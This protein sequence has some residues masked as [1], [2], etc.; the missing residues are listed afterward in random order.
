MRRAGTLVLIA[1]SLGLV[2][3]LVPTS[4]ASAASRTI[5]I[6]DPNGFNVSED[7]RDALRGRDVI[8]APGD[9]VIFKNCTTFNHR[10]VIDGAGAAAQTVAPG[11][12]VTFSFPSQGTFT[13]SCAFHS[14]DGGGQILVTPGGGATTTTAAPTTIGAVT[15]I[16]TGTT[17]QVVRTTTTRVPRTTTTRPPRTTTTRRT[18]STIRT[19]SS[20]VRTTTTRRAPTTTRQPPSTIE[21]PAPVTSEPEEALPTT[22]TGNDGG[23]KAARAIAVAAIAATFL[24]LVVILSLARRRQPVADM[25][26]PPPDDQGSA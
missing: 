21:L 8:I 23:D 16:P 6:D 17:T 4:P 24:T 7:C 15:T 5:V 25:P 18:P 13:Y 11:Q 10:I 2:L 1:L 19:P 22:R 14:T 9:S 3:P 26:P 12:S 20:V